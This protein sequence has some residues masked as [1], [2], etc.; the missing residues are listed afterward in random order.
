LAIHHR[1]RKGQ[2]EATLPQ[3]LVWTGHSHQT[4][5][6]PNAINNDTL[7]SW[8]A[9]TGWSHGNYE[10]A[11]AQPRYSVSPGVDAINLRKERFLLG[12]AIQVNDQCFG[13]GI[14]TA[15]SVQ[16][17][18]PQGAN[19]AAFIVSVQAGRRCIAQRMWPW[20]SFWDGSP[21]LRDEP[22]L[23]RKSQNGCT[24]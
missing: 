10:L 17:L 13:R 12:K 9:M 14:Q 4:V 21:A 15:G 6:W 11:V 24:R 16:E 19:V 18:S 3:G 23:P 22:G 2:L 1:E 8:T 7:R 20:Y 5:S